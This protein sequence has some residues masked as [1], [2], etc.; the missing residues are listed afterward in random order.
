MVKDSRITVANSVSLDAHWICE[1]SL[2]TNIEE[3]IE[4]SYIK[5][6]VTLIKETEKCDINSSQEIVDQ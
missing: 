5:C 1:M 3:A 4:R 2:F 6:V